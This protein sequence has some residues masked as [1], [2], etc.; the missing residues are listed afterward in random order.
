M[1]QSAKNIAL[2]E[3]LNEAFN[4]HDLDRIMSHFAEECSL[5]MPRGSEPWGS[6]EIQICS[7]L[8]SPLVSRNLKRLF[9]STVMRL[10]DCNLIYCRVS[11][12]G[13][14]GSQV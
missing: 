12:K 14:Q 7:G 4:S 11:Q 2:L 6:T 3:E 13:F 9:E 5:D 1:D 10:I 8:F